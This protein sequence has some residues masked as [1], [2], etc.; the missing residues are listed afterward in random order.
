MQMLHPITTE[1][2]AEVA[3]LCVPARVEENYN[4][5]NNNNNLEI[6]NI[7]NNKPPV[8]PR[9]H[10]ILASALMAACNGALDNPVN[11]QGL[12]N[13][14][15]PI[16]WIEEGCDMRRDILPTLTAIGKSAHGRRIRSWKFFSDAIA[17]ARD[18]RLRGMPQ[19]GRG[20]GP[21]RESE[22][23]KLM[24]LAERVNPQGDG[25]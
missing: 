23:E 22:A 9:D 20:A 13:M 12:L 15:I 21:A 3:T 19:R 11:C 2:P 25:R 10:E 6:Y 18:D 4:K 16:M 17:Q 8:A 1:T 14:G 7:Y 24:R 5:Y